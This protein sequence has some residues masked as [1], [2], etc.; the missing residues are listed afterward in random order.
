MHPEHPNIAPITGWGAAAA[1]LWTIL[2]VSRVLPEHM[3]S[4]EASAAI[5]GAVT[6]LGA[7]IGGLFAR[8]QSIARNER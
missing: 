2:T 5:T 1:A 3:T 6:T 8:R 4:P 7:T